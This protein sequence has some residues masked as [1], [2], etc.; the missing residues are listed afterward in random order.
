MA[1]PA[2]RVHPHVIMAPV[3][4]F[5]LV[6]MTAQARIRETHL[7]LGSSCIDIDTFT[8]PHD[9]VTPVVEQVHMVPGHVVQCR[10]ATVSG[11]RF[12]QLG[13]VARFSLGDIVPERKGYQRQKNRGW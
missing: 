6:G 4:E 9:P 1:V 5:I 3:A 12:L 8:I 7:V 2:V 13:D 11:R 10:N